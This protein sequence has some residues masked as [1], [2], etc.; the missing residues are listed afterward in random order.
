MN[1]VSSYGGGQQNYDQIHHKHSKD[2]EITT[3]QFVPKHAKG[4]G[5]NPSSL[6][7]LQG[8]QQAQS[9]RTQYQSLA[10]RPTLSQPSEDQ[11]PFNKEMISPQIM[12]KILNAKTQLPNEAAVSSAFEEQLSLYAQQNNLSQEEVAKLRFAFYNPD[13]TEDPQVKADAEVLS[14]A[15]S[16]KLQEKFNLPKDFKATGDQEAFSESVEGTLNNAFEA[17]LALLAKKMNLTDKQVKELRY[18]HYNPGQTKASPEMQKMLAQLEN[19][20]AKIVRQEYGFPASWKPSQVDGKEFNVEIEAAYDKAFENALQNQMP[21]LTESQKGLLRFM[22]Y[23]PGTTFPGSAELEE[24]LHTMELNTLASLQSALGLPQ[25]TQIPAASSYFTVMLTGAFQAAL[26][27]C[28]SE[29]LDTIKPPMNKKDKELLERALENPDDP[30]IPPEIRALAAKIQGKA[31]TAVREKYQLPDVWAPDMVAMKSLPKNQAVTMA[32]NGINYLN[33]FVKSSYSVLLDLP[34]G[35]EKNSLM[36]FLKIINDAL[37]SLKQFLYQMVTANNQI[38]KKITAAKLADQKQKIKF[39]QEAQNAAQHKD[40]GKGGGKSQSTQKFMSIFMKVITPVM[41]AITLVV[42]VVLIVVTCGADSPLIISLAIVIMVALTALMVADSQAQCIAKFFEF[43][44]KIIKSMMPDWVPDQLTDIIDVVVKVVIIMAVLLVCCINP[45][46]LL[47]VGLSFGMQALMESNIVQEGIGVCG[48]NKEAQAIA[49]M[50]VGMVLAIVVGAITLFFAGKGP[51]GE[52]QAGKQIA[53]EAEVVAGE[54]AAVE[55]ISVQE[56][57][58]GLQAEKEGMVVAEGISAGA[59]TESVAIAQTAGKTTETGLIAA[60]QTQS[61]IQRTEKVVADFVQ[62][63]KKTFGEAIA[64]NKQAQRF[65]ESISKNVK[66][67]FKFLEK[68]AEWAKEGIDKFISLLM[69]NK[70]KFSME[71]ITAAQMGMDAAA[72]TVQIVTGIQNIQFNMDMAAL[73]LLEANLRAAIMIV[74]GLIKSLEK[75]IELFMNGLSNT[76]SWISNINQMQ[77]QIWSGASAQATHLTH[78]IV[79]AA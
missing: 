33:D 2:N 23:N 30:T 41:M 78:N 58:G 6:T 24:M 43:V 67:D 54:S 13:A 50:V 39:F 61:T 27:E 14:N 42:A 35:P 55:K 57:S 5:E 3:N 22:H 12:Q 68:A 28:L 69:K 47:T 65:I 20:A 18:A 48:G 16:A 46:V 29:Y 77:N 70:W 75:E 44:S 11:V 31:I 59:V 40:S 38:A 25:G 60:K 51:V 49:A 74:E 63:I 66:A 36:D 19:A 72:Q 21:P 4:V 56:V 32:E 52:I 45:M 79:R 26:R 53:G 37:S 17:Q 62:T 34:Q 9:A 73:A 15:A 64:N 8:Q 10:N 76:V 1:D 7:S 71:T